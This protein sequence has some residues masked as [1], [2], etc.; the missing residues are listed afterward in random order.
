MPDQEIESGIDPAVLHCW[1]RL[2]TSAVLELRSRISERLVDI[3][4]C[5][6]LSGYG[7]C[8]GLRCSDI[9][10]CVMKIYFVQ[11]RNIRSQT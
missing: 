1:S 6:L 8:A 3:E 2:W 10:C 7:G 5:G 11:Q 4:H 9:Y